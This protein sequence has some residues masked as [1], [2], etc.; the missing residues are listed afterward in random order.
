[1]KISL[2]LYDIHAIL[3]IMRDNFLRVK[4]TI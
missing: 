4:V 3:A 1:M 2:Q